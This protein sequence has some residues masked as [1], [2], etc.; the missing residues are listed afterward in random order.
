MYRAELFHRAGSPRN[1]RL[2]WESGWASAARGRE[3]S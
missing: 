1:R 3:S 2:P